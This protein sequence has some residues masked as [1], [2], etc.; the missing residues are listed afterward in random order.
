MR[1]KAVSLV[2]SVAAVPT[3]AICAIF[4]WEPFTQPGRPTNE[5]EHPPRH[6]AT[7][8]AL[9]KENGSP[10]AS[11]DPPPE[12]TTIV[13][14]S[15]AYRAE[16]PAGALVA[17]SAQLV[18]QLQNELKRMGCY[19]HDINGDWT[20]ATRAAMKDFLDRANAV[21]PL[22]APDLAHLALLKGQSEPLCGTNCPPGQTM[23]KG[24]H[25]LPSALIPLATKHASIVT[26]TMGSEAFNTPVDGSAVSPATPARVPRVRREPS[27]PKYGSGFFGLFGF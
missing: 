25:C 5:I 19:S 10:Q 12:I 4:F 11:E 13:I 24:N 15:R 21:L 27:S 7:E 17:N 23:A 1:T 22:G 8:P 16:Q 14:S 3:V 26:T 18:R 2:F 9:T 6:A 20:P